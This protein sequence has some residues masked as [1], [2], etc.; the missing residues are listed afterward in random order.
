M[1][2]SLSL[3]WRITSLTVAVFAAAELLILFPL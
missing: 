1:E 2:A 3:P